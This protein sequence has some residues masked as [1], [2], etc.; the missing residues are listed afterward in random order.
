MG[1][2]LKSVVYISWP[3]RT[4]VN[5]FGDYHAV[6]ERQPLTNNLYVDVCI[7]TPKE[8][9]RSVELAASQIEGTM[10]TVMSHITQ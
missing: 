2:G 8:R 3:L 5:T 1:W 6:Q 4:R 9:R 10:L 7:G